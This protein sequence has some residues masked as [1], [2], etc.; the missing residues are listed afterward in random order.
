M[1]ASLATAPKGGENRG[2]N[3]RNDRGGD[4]NRND[5]GDRNGQQGQRRDNRDGGRNDRNDRN[6]RNGRPG[7]RGPRN[8]RNDRGQQNRQGGQNQH[9]NQAPKSGSQNDQQA[10]QPANR[11]T[12][13]VPE[14]KLVDTRKGG[15]VNLDKYDE[16][17]ETLAP[18]R[19]NRM[20]SGKQKFQGRNNHRKGGY[21]RQQAP[22]GRAGK[23]CASL[24]LE[25][26]KKTPLTV[27]I[28]DEIGVGELASRMKKTGA[29][30]VK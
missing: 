29:E 12:S 3:D 27:K 4:R 6:D 15:N 11:P 8:D 30:V 1:Q 14:K 20:Q 26:A 13:R 23:D 10:Q 17:L 5:R 25:I 9:N 19:A 28:P 18:E 16:R 2:R 7:D 22:P 21:L 24:Q